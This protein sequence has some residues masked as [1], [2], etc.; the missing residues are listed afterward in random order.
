MGI[1]AHLTELKRFMKLLEPGKKEKNL[2]LS[3]KL[4]LGIL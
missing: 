2:K 4:Y 1:L 3:K